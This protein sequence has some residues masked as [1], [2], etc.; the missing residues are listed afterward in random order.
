[1]EGD[2]SN[3]S[4]EAS[5]RF[6]SPTLSASYQISLCFT[7]TKALYSLYIS[8][9]RRFLFNIEKQ[10]IG[11]RVSKSFVIII[12][13]IIIIIINILLTWKIVE[14]SKASVIYIYIYIYR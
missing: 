13:I 10:S 12:I 11:F 5:L 2:R 6:L 14:V 8:L 7:F 1:M 4:E 3:S 9:S